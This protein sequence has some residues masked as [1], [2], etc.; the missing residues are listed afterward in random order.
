MGMRLR[1]GPSANES[2]AKMEHISDADYK[3][4]QAVWKAF[5]CR[6]LVDYHDLY[7]K[8][9]V[10]LLAD[11]FENFRTTCLKHYGLDPAHYYTSTGIS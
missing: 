2:S 10:L 11:V 9:D 5:E 6:N 4:A 3:H 1:R 8:T 7:L